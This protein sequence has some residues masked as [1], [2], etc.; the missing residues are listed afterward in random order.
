MIPVRYY[1]E[2]NHK[3]ALKDYT[4]ISNNFIRR[5][6]DIRPLDCKVYL[7]LCS[8]VN[9]KEFT[10]LGLM[11]VYPSY[12]TMI[13]SLGIIRSQL[14][15]SL[16]GLWILGWIRCVRKEVYTGK[17]DLP[18]NWKRPHRI[19]QKHNIYILDEVESSM[20]YKEREKQYFLYNNLIEVYLNN[21]RSKEGKQ[22]MRKKLHYF[23]H[24]L[25]EPFQGDMEPFYESVIK[26]FTLVKRLHTITANEDF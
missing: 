17:G 2:D 6:H 7:F 4:V 25:K 24:E 11:E 21:S 3:Y 22:M 19:G 15:R 26:E 10:E 23:L 9:T 14:K 13:E 18:D 8:Y 16:N 1:D 20:E 12:E 5:M